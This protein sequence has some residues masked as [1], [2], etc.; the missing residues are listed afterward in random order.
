M[1]KPPIAR[2]TVAHSTWRVGRR[3]E[4]GPAGLVVAVVAVVVWG[5]LTVG[6]KTAG[7]GDIPVVGVAPDTTL[8]LSVPM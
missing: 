7:A 5:T 8:T 1:A 4:D 6:D 3:C 2:A